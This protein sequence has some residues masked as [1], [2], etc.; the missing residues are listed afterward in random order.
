MSRRS[1][2][3][4][5][6]ALWLALGLAGPAAA[7]HID[8]AA[9]DLGGGSVIETDLGPG[10]LA[11]DPAFPGFAPMR[12]VIQLEDGDFGAPIAW[13]ALVD[14][15]SGELWGGFSI[16][17]E[18]AAWDFVGSASA[19]AGAV[20]GIDADA[21]AVLVRFAPPG[22]P[23]G[24]DLGAAA[25]T[26]TDWRIDLG[27]STAASFV[28]VLAPVAVPEPGLALL[29]GVGVAGVGARLSRRRRGS[30]GARRAR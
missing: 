17:L 2:A 16:R 9:S 29:V 20:A 24:L 5:A 4:G 21:Q 19:N 11:F 27:A 15:L 28:M 6:L 10:T 14:N 25:G 1:L 22:E 26:G 23:A 30:G 8:L 3:R 18:G 7:A 12:L 13:N